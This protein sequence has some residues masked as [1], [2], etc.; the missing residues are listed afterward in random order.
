ME[1]ALHLRPESRDEFE[2]AIICALPVER[3]AI[4]ALLEVDY[5]AD[6]FSYKKAEGDPNTY[7]TG[8]LGNQHVV[9]AYMPGMGMVPTA[10]VASNLRSSFRNIK[11]GIV[12]GIC[13][14]A[15]KT[16]AGEEILLGDVIISTSVIQID[17]G[18]QYPH[19]F[20]RKKKAEDTL[21]R[22][23]PEIRA[24]IGKMSG[25]LMSSRL[26]AK[27]NSYS[28]ELCSR[29]EFLNFAYP[30]LETDRLHQ[31]DLQHKHLKQGVC[32]IC[33]TCNTSGCDVCEEALA[34]SCTELGCD[35]NKLVRRVRIRQAM[36]MGVPEDW[37]SITEMKEALKSWI[38]FGRMACSNQVVK[39]GPERDRI[40]A[41]E[42]AI[43]FEMESA[44]IWDL[45]PTVVIKS[46]CEYAESHKDKHW[47][48]YAAATAASCTKAMLEEWRSADRP[49]QS[50]INQNKSD[51]WQY[52]C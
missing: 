23:S 5:E 31:A 4:E 48:Q 43:G 29:K 26:K 10:A 32:S 42:G 39:T 50:L 36:E 47:Q 12:V 21:G 22:A 13:G 8:R 24:F 51:E 33:E 45:I 46:V 41:E 49:V 35:G 40:A 34:A 19:R 37:T 14:G 38:H 30:G 3:N 20:I 52:Q 28:L 7:T 2:I 11:V 18:R 17:F 25:N 16:T 1:G 9:L 27:T 15:T 44:G 6:G